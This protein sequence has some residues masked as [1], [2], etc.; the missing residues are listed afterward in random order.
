MRLVFIIFIAS[1]ST[2]SLASENNHLVEQ[3]NN[4]PQ[5]SLVVASENNDFRYSIRPEQAMIPA[6]TLKLLT[7]LLALET[8]GAEHRFVTDFDLDSDGYLWIKGYGDPFLISEEIDLIVRGLQKRGL[9]IINGIG[10]D[11][12][13]FSHHISIDGQTDSDNP[14]DAS[15]SPL[16]ANF[17]TLYVKR[18]KQGT[19]SA[20]A[21]TPLTPIM[22]SLARQLPHGEHRINLGSQELSSRYF[23]EI[24]TAKLR[25]AGIQV[26]EQLITG[27]IPDTLN[28]YYRHQN[29]HDLAEIITAMLQYSNN[30]IAN[31]LFLLL[32]VEATG[33]PASMAKSQSTVAA[34]IQAIFGWQD[35]IILEGSGLSRNNRLS[36]RQMIDILQRLEPY[37]DLLSHQNDRI[38]A[39]SGTLKGISTYAGYLHQNNGWVP[40]AIMI[41][42]PVNYNFRKQIAEQL[43]ND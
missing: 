43:L 30:F 9:T 34:K 2:S 20:E 6:S 5:A 23:A 42:Q 1:I 14:Y 10:I 36:A 28:P 4:M 16:A 21:Q 18:D 12:S 25:D 3:L 37:R 24:L 15:L 19:Q 7:A 35:Y 22:D 8:W 29:S 38:L 17:N 33:A 32:G 26:N 27:T 39:K 13:Y 41:N 11:N 31:Q 40:F